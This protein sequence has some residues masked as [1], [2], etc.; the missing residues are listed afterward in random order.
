MCTGVRE[1]RILTVVLSAPTSAL[2]TLPRLSLAAATA[3]ALSIAPL[4]PALSD[5]VAEFQPFCCRYFLQEMYKGK[6]GWR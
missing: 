3:F 4:T 6:R 2:L 1:M 5:L